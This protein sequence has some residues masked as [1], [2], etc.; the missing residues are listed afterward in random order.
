M[1]GPKEHIMMPKTGE[2]LSGSVCAALSLPCHTFLLPGDE[3]D[4]CVMITSLPH[5]NGSWLLR[6]L[7]RFIACLGEIKFLL[8]WSTFRKMNSSFC[9]FPREEI[10][11]ERGRTKARETALRPPNLPQFKVCSSQHTI[12][13]GCFSLTLVEGGKETWWLFKTGMFVCCGK[14]CLRVSVLHLIIKFP[15]K[16]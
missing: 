9:A 4:H 13:P 7:S 14:Y 3:K 10:E 12:C 6:G 16:T 1:T 11:W 15:N 5:S 2:N 8:S